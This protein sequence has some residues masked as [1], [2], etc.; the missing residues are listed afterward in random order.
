MFSYQPHIDSLRKTLSDLLA[1]PQSHTQSMGENVSIL[2]FFTYCVEQ[3]E[4]D[5]A[6]KNITVFTTYDDGLYQMVVNP[7]QLVFVTETLLRNGLEQT[8]TNGSIGL[9][10]MGDR[11]HDTLHITI[12]DTGDGQI[13]PYLDQTSTEPNHHLSQVVD[14][15]NAQEGTISTRGIP[16]RGSSITISIPWLVHIPVDDPPAAEDESDLQRIML[17]EDNLV[18]AD[19]IANYLRTRGFHVFHAENGEVALN[20]LTSFRPNLILMD[21][22]MPVM[23]GLTAINHIRDHQDEALA[24]IPIIALTALS[25]SSD[26]KDC[27]EAGADD[28]ISKPVSL[29]WLVETIHMRLGVP[30]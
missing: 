24:E 5:A 13:S 30:A 19:T 3:I 14:A 8:P 4:A 6:E 16:S 9:E 25:M 1:K 11:R 12:W 21:I 10:V 22:H 2:E 7:Q 28:Y 27:L 26:R 15:I 20:K 29:R 18:N 23:D 17:V